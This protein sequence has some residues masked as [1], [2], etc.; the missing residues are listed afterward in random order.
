MDPIRVALVVY[1]RG[2]DDDKYVTDSMLMRVAAALQMQLTRDFSRI[3]RIPAVV[4]PFKSLDEVPPGYLPLIIVKT[5]SLHGSVH[6]FHQTVNGQP[7]GVVERGPGWSLPASHELL[8]MVCD[9][10]GRLTARGPSVA[11]EVPPPQRERWAPDPG[12]DGQGEVAYLVEACDPCQDSCYT[13]GEFEVSD[14]VL[15]HYYSASAGERGRYSF[16]G[17]VIQPRQVLPLGYVTWYTSAP[18][19]AIWQAHCDASGTLTVAP[20]A[21]PA[22][23]DSRHSVDYA[24]DFVR[25]GPEPSARSAAADA[26]ALAKASAEAY[27]TQLEKD[28]KELLDSSYQ[29]PVDVSEFLKVLH[30]VAHQSPS[31]YEKYRKDPDSMMKEFTDA[32]VIKDTYKFVGTDIP[33]QAALQGAYETLNRRHERN[34]TLTIPAQAAITAMYGTTIWAPSRP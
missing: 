7:I 12:P 29:P 21:G 16:T 5:G 31:E 26:E 8:E 10:Y 1:E 11:D 24:T 2:D 30:K 27:G 20:L 15:P 33:K 3:W 32:G 25:G 14:F 34:R 23:A 9:P 6:A 22:S 19:S 18:G 4:S 17:R 13:I 28:L